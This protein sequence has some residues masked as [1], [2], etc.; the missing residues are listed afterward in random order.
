[1]QTINTLVDNLLIIRSAS[2]ILYIYIEINHASNK[3]YQVSTNLYKLKFLFCKLKF[4]QS[5]LIT[6][7]C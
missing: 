6:S 5:I 4:N 3:S 2:H 7:T 1:M